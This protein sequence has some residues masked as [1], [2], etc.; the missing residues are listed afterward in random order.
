MNPYR[1][2]QALKRNPVYLRETGAS[3]GTPNSFYQQL[4]RFSPFIVI[5]AISSGLCSSIINPALFA[6]NNNLFAETCL[7]CLPG[8][9][10]TAVTLYVQIMVPVLTAPTISKERA[11]G[12]WDIL[13]TTPL[14]MRSIFLAKVF[15]SLSRLRIW[16]GLFALTL[17]KG[18]IVAFAQPVFGNNLMWLAGV[19]GL[20]VMLHPWV[21]IIFAACVGV[22]VSTLARTAMVALVAAYSIIV[23]MKIFNSSYIWLAVVWFAE[24]DGL[25]AMLLPMLM[26]IVIYSLLITAVWLGLY[27]QA[28]ILRTE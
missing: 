5:G 25:A 12:T 13:R 19:M 17:L 21:E 20:V 22:Y 9:L 11:A 18:G 14:S 1:Q 28:K 27:R 10:I 26:P 3:W 6:V 2:W 4:A 7:T 15:G 23:L 24:L 8:F 16:L